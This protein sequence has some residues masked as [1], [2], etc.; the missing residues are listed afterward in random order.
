MENGT[1]VITLQG[2]AATSLWGWASIPQFSGSSDSFKEGFNSFAPNG[3]PAHWAKRGRTST[4]NVQI[5]PPNEPRWGIQMPT[6]AKEIHPFIED[7]QV[8]PYSHFP[9][10]NLS[11]SWLAAILGDLPKSSGNVQG[12]HDFSLS[13]PFQGSQNTTQRSYV[14][15]RAKAETV[16][17]LSVFCFY[18]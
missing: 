18:P 8:W 9:M 13:P 12:R 10:L 4:E 6:A 3:P 17:W 1:V 2:H 16:R 14:W 15:P 7:A 11:F 5:G